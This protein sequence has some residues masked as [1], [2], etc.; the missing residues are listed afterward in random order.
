MSNHKKDKGSGLS[1]KNQDAL[2]N[3]LKLH[4]ELE[5]E[6]QQHNIGNLFMKAMSAISELKSNEKVLEKMY[7][8]T[9]KDFNAHLQS[10]LLVKTSKFKS[11]EYLN[12]ILNDYVEVTEAATYNLE[13]YKNNQQ[14]FHEKIEVLRSAKHSELASQIGSKKNERQRHAAYKHLR[15]LLTIQPELSINRLASILEV[16]SEKDRSKFFRKI[17]FSTGKDYAR[18]IKKEIESSFQ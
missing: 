10:E 17:P 9:Y 8:D 15:D 3:E 16:D 12:E 18:T 6:L 13:V 11:E 14:L 5:G 2:F 1:R 7:V 4:L